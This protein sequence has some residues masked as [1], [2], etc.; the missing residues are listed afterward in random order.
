MKNIVTLQTNSD[1]YKEL[2]DIY[3]KKIK[4]WEFRIK[5]CKEQSDN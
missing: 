1:D 4:L 3:E 2:I 5:I